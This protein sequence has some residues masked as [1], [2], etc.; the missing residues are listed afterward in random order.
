VWAIAPSTDQAYG[1]W[2]CSVSQGEKWSLI[3]SKSKPASSAA[4]A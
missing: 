4:L 2:P 1:A 3:T